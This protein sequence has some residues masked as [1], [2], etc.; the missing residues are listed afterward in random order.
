MVIFLMSRASTGLLV[1][2]RV[3]PEPVVKP[4]VDPEPPMTVL[5]KWP[6]FT[7]KSS[8]VVGVALTF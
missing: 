3:A 5:V 2:T 6:L 1:V 4:V 7:L 8:K